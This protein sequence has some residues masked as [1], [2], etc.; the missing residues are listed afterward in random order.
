MHFS[1]VKK[2]LLFI[3]VLSCILELFLF[4]SLANI[5]G[6]ITCLLSTTL[7]NKFVFTAKNVYKRTLSFFAVSYV[8]L[9][10]YLAL[11][12]TL[13][14]GNEISHHM[15]NPIET[16]S[17]QFAYW[18]ITIIAYTC[19]G[20]FT[21]DKNLIG[22]K[23]L[24][25][26]N[27]FKCPSFTQ[28][29]IYA[30]MGWIPKMYL[31]SNQYSN[32]DESIAGQGISTL[33]SL[34]IFV[35]ITLLFN[36]LFGGKQ[37]SKIQKAIT[38]TYLIFLLVM[39]ISSNSRGQMLSVFFII[40]VC[41]VFKKL[42]N[43]Q[44]TFKF[45]ARKIAIIAIALVLGSGPLSDMA[46]SMLIVRAQRD[47]LSYSELM[48]ETFDLFL[49]KEQLEFYKKAA[50]QLSDKDGG[51]SSL[52]TEWDEDYVTNI[53]L[54]RLCNYRV[55]D[56]TIYHADKVGH[57]NSKMFDF[58]V[59][60]IIC[61]APQPLLDFL[62]TGIK[63]SDYEYSAMDYLFA[64]S[65]NRAVHVS[66]IV[67]GDVGLGLATFGFVYFLLIF[68][69]Y[70]IEF[71]LLDS[72]CFKKKNGKMLCSV[73]ILMNSISYVV[74]FKI[75]AGMVEHISFIIYTLPLSII[76]SVVVCFFVKL[77]TFDFQRHKF[78]IVR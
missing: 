19:S 78:Q 16:F 43:T 41:W 61:L 72:L 28:A 51:G 40:G 20:R 68:P 58:F 21:Y 2:I 8:F 54:Q 67:G 33:L 63:K 38:Y 55:V 42:Q 27:F 70:S 57:A 60:Q 11:P 35:P 53:F 7:Y 44:T 39:L 48:K 3:I 65:K 71:V 47:K 25:K 15:Y 50:E 56:A 5:T 29:Y 26:L 32:G 77:I 24:Y 14:D 22:T 6:C 13:I 59:H 49:D 73:F 12:A 52:S 17:L 18:I 36:P 4:P 69:I 10:M 66:Y 23:L 76:I 31:L 37:I 1:S 30:L 75:G 34:F 9:L 64:I 62:S 74:R 45:S 46:F